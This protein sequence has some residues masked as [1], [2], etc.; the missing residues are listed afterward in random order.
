[1][2]PPDYCEYTECPFF[3]LRVEGDCTTMDIR[4]MRKVGC[5]YLDE[6][7]ELL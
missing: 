3:D 1:M 5:P 2:K 7:D 6:E 4:E